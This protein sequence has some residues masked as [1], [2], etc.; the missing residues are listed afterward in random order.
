MFHKK[1]FGSAGGVI[2][3]LEVMNLDPARNDLPIS[4]SGARDA[5][6]GH[7]YSKLSS[8]TKEK[9]KNQILPIK[10]AFSM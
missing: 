6:S 7:K 1:N 2:Y 4:K 8:I 3:R 9:I 10:Y 5:Q